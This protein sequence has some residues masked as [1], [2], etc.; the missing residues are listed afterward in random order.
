MSYKFKTN[1]TAVAECEMPSGAESLGLV[2]LEPRILL[3]AAG[4]V[5]GAEIAMEAL[6]VEMAEMGVEAIFEGGQN[7]AAEPVGG[8]WLGDVAAEPVGGPWLGAAAAEPVGGP[9][10]GDIAAEPVGGPW[11]GA[12][13]AEPVGGPWLG[14]VAA[15]PVG[16]PWL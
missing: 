1:K 8:P 12:A 16:G 11:L 9:W 3:D 13:A 10:L 4:F 15:D 6:T 2:S 7:M 5:T 14:D